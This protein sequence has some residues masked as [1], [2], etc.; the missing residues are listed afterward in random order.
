[1]NIED[2][3]CTNEAIWRLT[4]LSREEMLNVAGI[5]DFNYN[6]CTEDAKARK[7]STEDAEATLLYKTP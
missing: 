5:R 7:A 2:I 4:N 1:M 3:P 6:P